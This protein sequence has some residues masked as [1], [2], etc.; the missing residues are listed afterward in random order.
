MV[1]RNALVSASQTSVMRAAATAAPVT[2]SV[3]R[4]FVGGETLVDAVETAANLS[5][6]GLHST[7]SHLGQDVEDEAGARAAVGVYVKTLEVLQTADLLDRVD[8]S[9][10]ASD[11]GINLPDGH[12]IAAANIRALAAAA[13]DAG[14]SVTVDME[15]YST[16][17]ATMDVFD[18]V[19]AAYP[20]TGVVVQ[21]NL[22]RSQVD[23]Q[24]LAA[25]P[26]RVRL[27]KGAYQESTDVA[28]PTAQEIDLSYVRA[29]KMLMAGSGTPLVATHDPRL[30][31][32]A[33]ALA[34]R[35][36]RSRESYEFQMSLGIRP[37]EQKR[38]AA[39]GAKV[40]VYVPFGSQ[41]YPYL[42]RRMAE[43]PANMTLIGRALIGRT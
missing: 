22:R 26:A 28:F 2:K 24:R 41:W 42:V 38:L 40:R 16:V 13:T 10:R 43:K 5:A 4:R 11:M 3:A 29:L 18:E 9:V 19:F 12:N 31:E 30:I 1:V 14:T 20:T 36:G 33:Q 15:D 35:S 34:V 17:A 37:E 39:A 27:V 6:E 32:I 21:A 25:T 8:L 7:L 23:C